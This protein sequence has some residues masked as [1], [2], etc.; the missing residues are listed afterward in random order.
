MFEGTRKD[1]QRRGRNRP[2]MF[3]ST[4]K[5]VLPFV[6]VGAGTFRRSIGQAFPRAA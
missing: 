4:R 5:D 3:A 1:A 2:G 6:S